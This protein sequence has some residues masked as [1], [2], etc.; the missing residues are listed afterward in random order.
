MFLGSGVSFGQ[1]CTPTITGTNPYTATF[2]ATGTC[3]WTVPC[4][5]TAI[6]VT[7]YGAGGAGGG[8]TTIDKNG[9]GGGGG[10]CSQVTNYAVTAG[11]IVTIVI[12]AGGSGVSAGNGNAGGFSSAT[13][14]AS[15]FC[16][17]AGGNGGSIASSNQG[18]GA[19]GAGGAIANNIPINAGF[20][21]GN[22]A[23]SDGSGASDLSGGGGGG[24]GTTAAGANGTTGGSG[25][26]GGATGGLAG[27]A[28]CNSSANGGAQGIA[29]TATATLFGGG[30]G[31]STVYNTG[32]RSGG[33]G[34]NGAIVITYTQGS[35]CVAP[36]SVILAGFTTPICFNNSPGTFTATASGGSGGAYTYQWYK[37]GSSVAGATNSTY[38]PGALTANTAFYCAVST[39]S[40]CTLNSGITTIIVNSLPSPSASNN[41]PICAG[42]ALNL[43]VGAYSLYSWNGPNGF[44]SSSQNPTIAA[45]TTSATGTYTVTVTDANSCQNISTTSAT[46]NATSVASVIIAVT[47]GAN[48]ECA[49][50]SI[51]F[52]AT[53]TNG[54]G[55]PFYQWKNNAAIIPGA[56]NSTYTTTTLLNNDAITCVMNSSNACATGSP[57]TSNTI[58]MTVYALPTTVTVTGGGTY[59]ASTTLTASN[60][61]SGTIYWQGTTPGGTSTTT[62]ST[63]QSVVTSG[64]YYFRAQNNGCWGSEGSATVIINPTSVGGSISGSAT[65]CS[66]SNSTLLTLSG[67]I[68]S[69][70]KWQYSTNGGGSWSDIANTSS[71][72][73]ATNLTVT[74]I[75]RA[76]VTSGVCSSANS[77]TAIVTITPYQDSWISM[78]VGSA[79]WCPGETRT[80]TVT[81]K[82][83]GTASWTNST[84]DINIGCKWDA[85][86]DYFVRTDANGLTTGNQQTY[87]F[88]MTA[89]LTTGTNHLTFDVVQESVCWFAG[90]SSCNSVY[91]S[92]ALTINAIPSI[93]GQ[94]SSASKCIG[95]SCTFSVTALGG[96]ITYQWRKGGVNI[97]GATNATYTIS[98]VAAG[99]V[100][101]Y[102]C[103]VA[104][105]CAPSVTSNT[106]SLTLGTV[107]AQP[108]A[109]TGNSSSCINTSQSYSVT[110]VAGV[111]YNWTIPAGWTQTSGGTTNS[112]TVIV[113]STPGMLAVTPHNAC[114]D[115][116]PSY[117]A[118]NLASCAG[119]SYTSGGPY[120]ITCGATNKFYDIGGAG[121]DYGNNQNVTTTFTAPAGRYL[122]V[123]F[124]DFNTESGSSPIGDHL[125]VYNGV[126]ATYPLIGD[127]SGGTLPPVLWSSTAGGSL[128]FV[129]VSDATYGN[130]RGF[131]ADVI[132]T[133]LINAT[134]PNPDCSNATCMASGPVIFNSG[135]TGG[136][137]VNDLPDGSAQKGCLTTNERNTSW[138]YFCVATSGTLNLDIFP[139]PNSKDYDFALYKL[140]SGCPSIA[141]IRCSY[142][143]PGGPTG[144]NSHMDYGFSTTCISGPCSTND[145][146]E[147]D[148]QGNSWVN[149]LPVTAGERY[150][151]VVG[152]YTSSGPSS[153]TIAVT[154]TATYNC[155]P[156]LLPVELTDFNAKCS[157]EQV[158]LNWSTASETNN[159]YFT[160]EKSTDNLNFEKIATINGA[161]TKNSVSNYTYSDEVQNHDGTAYYRLSQTD[162]DGTKNILETRAVTCSESTSGNISIYP[163]PATDVVYISLNE[164]TDDNMIVNI[165][166]LF[167]DNVYTE[168]LKT[169]KGK[170]TFAINSSNFKQGIYSIIIDH[171]RYSKSEKLLISK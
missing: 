148:Q 122:C 127:Y 45:A 139:N 63:S 39:G 47:N 54:G 70:T 2:T 146:S 81:I 107:P 28:G 153:A 106:A 38:S 9:G 1:S 110:N 125:Y 74:T 16:K 51:T 89:P 130:Y 140:A 160:L 78:N 26:A 152:D 36:T 20:K 76:V 32:S 27:G 156:P 73:T 35:C 100:G 162:Y 142:S 30:G 19:G 159:D 42:N 105:N 65:V 134:A 136:G 120:T 98:S 68:G 64:T 102:D 15:T 144:I 99:D 84:P 129:F 21:G 60:G 168:T 31:G 43:S 49:G 104:G 6:T 116:T 11:T 149:D 109:I 95:E 103:L 167:G 128:T 171:S 34:A 53:P 119:T 94:P 33:P 10:A 59:C 101:N 41:G 87:S 117:L 114:G 56:T 40:G 8:A 97:A 150:V 90:C 155:N 165:Y 58:T 151:L 85:D 80:V 37:A 23:S 57:A 112:I 66:G 24:A 86:A 5:V 121:G 79:N 52:T 12:G 61:S 17:A 118:V 91:T 164:E 145:N 137:A 154:G 113:G 88:S 48:P 44:T 83:V 22:G 71:T 55:A 161:G 143:A 123:I 25:G 131:A 126:N 111:T 3:T 62:P 96:G 169:I 92:S 170:N 163:N 29:A 13:I 138:Y 108:S 77:G 135:N 133:P 14:G 93:S 67:H 82:N 69:V 115:G 157:D 4:G 75:Y 124:Y 7:T 141:P 166:N 147:N 46:V 18:I 158:K 72:Y 132:C 50:S